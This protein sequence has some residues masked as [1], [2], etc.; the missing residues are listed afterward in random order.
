NRGSRLEAASGQEQLDVA[1]LPA[2]APTDMSGFAGRLDMEV[3]V[4]RTNVAA[5]EAVELTVKFNGTG[6]LKLLDAPEL[7][8]PQDFEVYDPETTDRIAVDAAGMRGSRTYR[9]LV[10]PRHEGSYEIPAIG[11]SYY[12]VEQGAYR[13][14]SGEPI[15][16]VVSAGQGSANSGPSLRKPEQ[17]RVELLDRDIRYIRTGDLEL[18]PHG[19][20]FLGSVGYWAGIGAPTLAFL[21]FLLWRGRHQRMAADVSGIRRRKADKVARQRLKEASAAL[22]RDDRSGFYEALHRALTT[23]LAGKLDIP[24]SRVD[25]LVVTERM[26]NVEGGADLADRSM[27][28]LE[29]CELAR[30]APVEDRPRKELHEQALQLVRDIE[31]QQNA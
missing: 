18:R 28:L 26:A 24:E 25:R 9:Y 13:S 22:E 27:A 30:F 20:H 10:I 12:D 16:L 31:D 29:A 7:D 11:L 3:S 4:D 17:R 14:L 1:P 8:L 5:N 6:N 19:K 15:T 23:Y 2:G 21:L